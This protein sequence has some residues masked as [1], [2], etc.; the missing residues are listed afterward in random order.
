M[1][2]RKPHPKQDIEPALKYAEKNGWRIKVG[3]GHAWGKLYC[4]YNDQDC[5][6]GTFC[7]FSIWGTPRNSGS[8]AK[9]ICRVINNCT[10]H[11]SV[12]SPHKPDE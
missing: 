4:P 9:Q 3:G 2:H 7:I 5:R 12:E 11:S 6:G 10:K 8:H 1:I